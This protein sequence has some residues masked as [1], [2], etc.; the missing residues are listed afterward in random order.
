MG[1]RRQ[2]AGGAGDQ[3]VEPGETVGE[4]SDLVGVTKIE[5][6]VGEGGQIGFV[7]RGE[8]VRAGDGHRRTELGECARGSETGP[9]GAPHDQH[10]TAGVVIPQVAHSTH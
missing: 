3:D 6:A 10:L 2:A 8:V 5:L 1:G 7:V 9:S 4:P